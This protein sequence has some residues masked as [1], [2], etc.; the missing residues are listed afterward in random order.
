[1][2]AHG[3]VVDCRVDVY[4]KEQNEDVGSNPSRD[5]PGLSHKEASGDCELQDSRQIN[6]KD[7]LR[8]PRW[9]H[10]RHGFGFSEVSHACENEQNAKSD[11]RSALSI[12]ITMRDD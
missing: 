6:E 12:E 1:M 3:D 5:S 8:Y 4:W 11:G 7:S 10:L 2:T 9:Q